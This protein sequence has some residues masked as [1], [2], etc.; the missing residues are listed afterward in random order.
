[1]YSQII[2]LPRR[3]SQ[4]MDAVFA[5]SGGG[6]SAVA[7]GDENVILFVNC[8]F[9]NNLATGIAF[10]GVCTIFVFLFSSRVF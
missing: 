10:A 7:D 3:R 4:D 9:M 5:G 1:M 8:T 2:A 6:V